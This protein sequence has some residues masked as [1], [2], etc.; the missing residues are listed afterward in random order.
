MSRPG[1]RR[2][3]ALDIAER[4]AGPIWIWWLEDEV[5]GLVAALI[6]IIRPV[7]TDLERLASP[8][9]GKAAVLPRSGQS[10]SPRN[11]I[12]DR[13]PMFM[14]RVQATITNVQALLLTYYKASRIY[15]TASTL[16][17]Q[18]SQKCWLIN[19][20]SLQTMRR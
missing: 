14:G 3:S 4:P 19:V 11:V 5:A 8:G 18:I 12:A 7:T 2:I 16:Q 15:R 10:C 17:R 9:P 20:F 13:S 1:C 6:Q